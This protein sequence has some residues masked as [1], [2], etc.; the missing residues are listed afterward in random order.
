MDFELLAR[1]TLKL[2][3]RLREGNNSDMDSSDPCFIFDKQLRKKNE[4]PTA[5]GLLYRIE[6]GG[7]TFCVRGISTSNLKFRANQVE[8]RSDLELLKKLK[9]TEEDDGDD[10]FFY[11]TR[12]VDQAVSLQK[13]LINRRFPLHEDVL[14]NLSDPGFSWWMDE[15]DESFTVY[16]KSHGIERV[17]KLR[18]LG[19]IGDGK[20]A[21]IYFN[22]VF[23]LFG[24]LFPVKEFS[25]TSKAMKISTNDPMS[26]TFQMFRDIFLNGL[27][28]FDREYP[29]TGQIFNEFWHYLDELALFRNFWLEIENNLTDKSEQNYLQ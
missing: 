24:L 18:Q 19:P 29:F 26:E 27:N 23:K 28:K 7:H 1:E 15:D 11:I 9:I 4:L 17:E 22:Q 12:N 2:S 21:R 20:K 6:E 13:N 3:V 10:L 25:C 14:C 16:F 5:P 8:R